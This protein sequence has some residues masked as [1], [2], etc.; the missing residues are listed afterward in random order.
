MNLTTEQYRLLDTYYKGFVRSGSLLN[1]EQKER[2]R[3]LNKELSALTL[4]FGN[5]AAR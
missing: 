3:E 4:Q 5:N 1:E 2:L